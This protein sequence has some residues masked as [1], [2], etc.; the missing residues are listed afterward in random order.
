M[1]SGSLKTVVAS[2]KV[3][4]FSDDGGNA[5][6]GGD[7]FRLHLRDGFKNLITKEPEI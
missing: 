5:R 4:N 7:V 6:F 3:T 2:V 1:P